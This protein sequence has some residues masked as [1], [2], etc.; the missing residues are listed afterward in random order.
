MSLLNTIQRGA[1]ALQWLKKPALGLALLF[2][3]AIFYI[4]FTSQSHEGDRYLV[5]CIIGLLW[6]LSAF[7]FIINFCAVPP[8][9]DKDAALFLR[10]KRR[11]RR[12]WYGLLAFLFLAATV[13][14]LIVSYRLLAVWLRS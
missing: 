5:P 2:L 4:V 6:S 9:A 14:V 3:L 13:A 1:A 12:L 10:L 8:Q 11:L 7:A